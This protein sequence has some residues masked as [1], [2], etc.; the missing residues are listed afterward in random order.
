MFSSFWH[1]S[2]EVV[3]TGRPERESSSIDSLPPLKLLGPKRYLVIGRRNITIYS[4]YPFMDFFRLLSLFC[5]EFYHGTKLQIPR[6][7]CRPA[8]HCTCHRPATSTNVRLICGCDC[9]YTTRTSVAL[10]LSIERCSRLREG[11]MFENKTVK[12]GSNTWCGITRCHI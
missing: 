7:H 12:E 9:Y 2:F 1:I 3:S 10:A 6:V 4:I 5:E 8:R 11:Q